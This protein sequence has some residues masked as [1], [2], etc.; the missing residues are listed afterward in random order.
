MKI[1]IV[2]DDANKLNALTGL[3]NDSFPEAVVD[4][5]RSLI[6][7]V[8][9]TR[10]WSP[11]VVLLDMT[12]PTYDQTAIDD[13]GAM[14][15]FGG[16]EF[17]RQIRRFRLSPRVFVV[18]QFETFGEGKSV[19]TREQLDIEL[20]REFPGIFQG[21]LH[22]HASLQEWATRLVEFVEH[23]KDRGVE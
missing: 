1:L 22:Y 4:S 23:T 5:A 13:G 15:A 8:R 9:R 20:S 14:E 19:Q 12:L 11:E 3:I 6:S 17:L 7:G 21:M 18:T 10:E 16:V 2:E